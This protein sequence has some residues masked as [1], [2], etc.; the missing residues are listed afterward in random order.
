MRDVNTMVGPDPS[1]SPSRSTSVF[2]FWK[3]KERPS[4]PHRVQSLWW[5]NHLDLRGWRQLRRF[6]CHAVTILLEHGGATWQHDRNGRIHADVNVTLHD[7]VERSVVDSAGLLPMT[8]GWKTLSQQKLSV[9]TVMFF[10]S[11]SM[12]VCFLL[13]LYAVDSS[14]V[15]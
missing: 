12:W 14:S 9:P 4:N 5:S 10:P 6:L 7:V 15:S 1:C 11:E 2:F 13:E 3:K 8:F